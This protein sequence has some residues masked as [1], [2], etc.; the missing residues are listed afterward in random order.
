MSAGLA[1]AKRRRAPCMGSEIGPG[2]QQPLGRPGSNPGAG[3]SQG[4]ALSIP[5]A[6]SMMGSRIGSLENFTKTNLEEVEKKFKEQDTFIVENI[7]NAPD[8]EQINTAFTDIDSRLVIC[9]GKLEKLNL[10]K[11][12]L[13]LPPSSLQT[14][15][16]E[17]SENN[18]SNLLSHIPDTISRDLNSLKIKIG[19]LDKQVEKYNFLDGEVSRLKKK[20]DSL[21]NIEK[22]LE[23]K[24]QGK[25]EAKINA[26]ME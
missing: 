5:Q 9:E 22:T 14:L 12:N 8:V 25:L 18:N 3:Q 16:E 24:I 7:G 10:S 23:A 17:A 1:A 20:V 19:W 6:I 13:S 11:S 15:R 2:S 4:S 26:K 21:T